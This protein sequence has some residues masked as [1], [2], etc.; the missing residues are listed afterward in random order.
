MRTVQWRT[1]HAQT[2]F[3]WNAN[4]L[5]GSGTQRWTIFRVLSLPLPSRNGTNREE[6]RGTARQHWTPSIRAP[7]ERSGK[8]FSESIFEHKIRV[9]R[10]FQY[11]WISSATKISCW[12]TGIK[13]QSNYYNL[14]ISRELFLLADREETPRVSESQTSLCSQTSSDFVRKFPHQQKAAE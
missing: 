4:L 1:C 9:F 12:N 5:T 6:P 2:V 14:F 7:R 8:R 10:S 13:I 3:C 11:Y